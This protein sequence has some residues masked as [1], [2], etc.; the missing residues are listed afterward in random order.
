MPNSYWLFVDVDGIPNTK[1]Q[2]HTGNVLNKT[3]TSTPKHAKHNENVFCIKYK[4]T[5]NPFYTDTRYNN[6]IPYN[7]NFMS[8]KL[9][10]SGDS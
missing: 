7:D 6:K 4:N 1:Y 8:R 2:I 9:R 5:V 3:E 10:S